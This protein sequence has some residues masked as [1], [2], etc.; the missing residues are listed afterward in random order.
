M[1]YEPRAEVSEAPTSVPVLEQQR[2]I[3]MRAR[4]D[5]Q[6]F[7]RQA[8]ERWKQSRKEG[9]TFKEG[10]Q[11]RLEGCNLHLDQPSTKLAPK[12]HGPFPIK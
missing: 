7:M 6:K 12:R 9:R 1:G 3:W 8:Q 11:V 4:D 2:D 5:A 10:D